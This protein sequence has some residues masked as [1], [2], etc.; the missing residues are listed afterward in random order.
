[1]QQIMQHLFSLTSGEIQL[2]SPKKSIQAK[3]VQ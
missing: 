3:T 2:Q 1:M